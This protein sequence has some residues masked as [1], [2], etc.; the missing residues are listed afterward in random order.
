MIFFV[1]KIR[2]KIAA[3]TNRKEKKGESSIREEAVF[4]SAGSND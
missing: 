2:P 1:A 3:G 4:V